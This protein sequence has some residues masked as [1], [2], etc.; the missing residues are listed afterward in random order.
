MRHHY[1]DDLQIGD[2]TTRFLGAVTELVDLRDGLVGQ[3]H[4]PDA[5]SATATA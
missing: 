1:F 2:S 4:G 3:G 5:A